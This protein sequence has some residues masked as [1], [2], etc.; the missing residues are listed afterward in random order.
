MN[1]L[2]CL[3]IIIPLFTALIFVLFKNKIGFQ[4]YL[5]CFP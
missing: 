2:V 4:K 5:P 3:P 1:N